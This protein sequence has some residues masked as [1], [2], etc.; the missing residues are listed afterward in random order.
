MGNWIVVVDDE[1]ISLTSAK[2]LLG[3]E[4]MKVSCLR[5]GRDLLKFMKKNDP[6]LILLDVMMPE[7]DGIETLKALR[8]QEKEEGKLETPVIFLTG[9]LDERME[10]L[11]LKLGASDYI[12]KPFNKDLLVRRIKNAIKNSRKIETLTENA[13]ID[14]LTGLL[15]KASGIEKI[16][17]L[18]ENMNGALIIL[19][20]DSFKLV[21]D[22]FGHDMGDRVL[23]AFAD[24]MRR[25]TRNDDVVSRVGGDEFLAF[26]SNMEEESAVSILTARLNDQLS[27]AAC[28][29]MGENHGI[30]LGISTGAVMVPKYG[31]E[32]EE[33]FKHAD[34]ALYEAKANGKHRCCVYTV[35][36]ENID[37]EITPAAEL[38]R[39]SKVLEERNEGKEALVLG[40][41]TFSAVYHFIIR[42]NRRYDGKAAK[43][44]FLLSAK[45]DSEITTEEIV[46]AFGSLLKRTLRRSDI[47]LKNKTNQYLVVFSMMEEP[48]ADKAVERI[49]KEWNE[50]PESRWSEVE[51]AVD[52][53]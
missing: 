41:E 42:F 28:E 11:G 1:A 44:L 39:L 50:F 17:E 10:H 19:D 2:T 14:K 35:A 4:D 38:K 9:D 29:L 24:I 40:M 26:F 52:E 15:N 8:E 37:E 33:L 48:N 23:A 25:N 51:F 49:L 43:V 13:T 53:S 22:L 21:N 12:H 3:S 5:S 16:S 7:M 36:E 47:I 32:Y 34:D 27:A 20:L 18:C 45:P 46:N 30:P 31:R 6:D